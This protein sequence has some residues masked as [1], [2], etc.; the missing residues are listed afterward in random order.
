MLVDLD[1]LSSLMKDRVTFDKNES[2]VIIVRGYRGKSRTH[3]I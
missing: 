3:A 2:F 1:M